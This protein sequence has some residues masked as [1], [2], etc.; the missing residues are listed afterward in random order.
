MYS[1]S[2][3]VSCH[4]AIGVFITV[5]ETNVTKWIVQKTD[6]SLNSRTLV[7]SHKNIQISKISLAQRCMEEARKRWLLIGEAMPPKKVKS[8]PKKTKEK[9][10]EIREEAEW[11]ET[12]PHKFLSQER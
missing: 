6:S 11:R 8:P 7:S 12:T 5:I 10:K 3:H 1:S 9:Q 4:S 2:E